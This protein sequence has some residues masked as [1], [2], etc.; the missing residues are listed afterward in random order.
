MSKKSK[1]KIW[2]FEFEVLVDVGL[3]EEEVKKE[4]EKGGE[5]GEPEGAWRCQQTTHLITNRKAQ[6]YLDPRVLKV[7]LTVEEQ[8]AE[9]WSEGP[10]STNTSNS[11]CQIFFFDFLD[12]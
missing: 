2:Q 7:R 12:I 9:N 3:E 4:E 6:T 10:R 5:K 8:Q 1:K 11:S